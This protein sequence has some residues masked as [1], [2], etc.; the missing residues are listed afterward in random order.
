[1]KIHTIKKKPLG[2][3]GTPLDITTKD[4]RS[5]FFIFPREQECIS[6]VESL[7]ALTTIRLPVAELRPPCI[8]YL[9]ADVRLLNAFKFR[10]DFPVEHATGHGLVTA[11]R[12]LTIT[13]FDIRSSFCSFY[14]AEAEF[15][16]MGLPN[17][18]WQQSPF[19]D[20]YMV[21]W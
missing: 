11:M 19:N 1:M 8:Q 3:E 12:A 16:R 15:K 17:R 14:N 2:A 7:T 6:L 9:V 21:R 4:F 10:P 18:D 20:Q 13:C 5:L